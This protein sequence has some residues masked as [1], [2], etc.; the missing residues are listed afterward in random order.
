MK[1]R[2][3]FQN[4]RYMCRQLACEMHPVVTHQSNHPCSTVTG[5]C[6]CACLS[7][8]TTLL[9]IVQFDMLTQ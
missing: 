7:F 4:S 2:K 8:H 9:N 6:Y 3:G 1:W 5:Q